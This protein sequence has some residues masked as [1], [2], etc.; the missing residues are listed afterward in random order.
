MNWNEFWLGPLPCH[1]FHP[2]QGVSVR[3]MMSMMLM[4]QRGLA[5]SLAASSIGRRRSTG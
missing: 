2:A 1:Q 3:P 5:A 4:N